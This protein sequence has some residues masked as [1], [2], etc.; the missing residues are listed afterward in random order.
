MIHSA[1]RLLVPLLVVC[2]A[3]LV[4]QPVSAGPPI[5]HHPLDI[6]NARSLPWQ[7]SS[8]WH[9]GD[10]KYDIR[11]LVSDVEALLVP[12]TPII[13]RMETLR[14]AAV[15]ASLD[16]DVAAQLFQRVRSRAADAGRQG[17]A[18]AMFDAAYLSAAFREM[19]RLAYEPQF[20]ARAERIGRLSGLDDTDRL[21][22]TALALRPD[23]HSMRF[24]A[25]I[26]AA[27]YDRAAALDH[28]ARARSG[29]AGDALLAAN[30][31]RFH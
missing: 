27:G 4:V 29:A 13:V 21:L 24:G 1:V 5:L 23:D 7:D 6:G 15:Y 17:D 16:G 18:L 3:L 31:D 11:R 28:L 8:H 2:A 30:L 25:A 12:G 19:A 9:Q 10:P 14:R 26:I 22:Q 20:R